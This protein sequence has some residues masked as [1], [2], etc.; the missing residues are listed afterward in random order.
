M[1]LGFHSKVVLMGKALAL[2]CLDEIARHTP[3]R[4]CD[5]CLIGFPVGAQ[6]LR[7]WR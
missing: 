5:C 7:R 3:A 4:I 6:R 2:I 1:K